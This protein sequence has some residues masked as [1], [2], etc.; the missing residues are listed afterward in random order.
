MERWST[1]WAHRCGHGALKASVSP[2]KFLY[3]TPTNIIYTAQFDRSASRYHAGVYKAKRA[4]LVGQLHSALSPLFLGQL[5]NL[6][7]AAV[8]KFR[9]KVLEG[10][11]GEGYDFGV[12]VQTAREEE[13]GTFVA[14][15]SG[16]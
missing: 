16:S 15:A 1:D 13:E 6:H 8:T 11:K 9:T 7:K 10:V 4:N 14:G 12:V 3:L 5:K 2:Q